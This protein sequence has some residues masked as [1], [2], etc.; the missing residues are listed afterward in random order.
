MNLRFCY[1]NSE[2]DLGDSGC[3]AVR[4]LPL[5]RGGINKRLSDLTYRV[6]P[7]I[8]HDFRYRLS[9]AEIR[10]TPMSEQKKIVK[11]LIKK[12]KELLK[13]PYTNI[14]ITGNL[15]AVYLLNDIKKFSHAFV[16]VNGIIC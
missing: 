13:Q 6:R 1:L 5:T 7:L 10:C 14:K 9:L 3:S 16:L 15:G 8:G 4:T 2:I 11:N 12:G